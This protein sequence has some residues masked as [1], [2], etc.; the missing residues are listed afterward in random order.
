VWLE[1]AWENIVYLAA[2][3]CQRSTGMGLT[4]SDIYLKE[5]AKEYELEYLEL[6]DIAQEILAVFLEK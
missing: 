3:K 4:I 1:D 2:I 5:F 6:A